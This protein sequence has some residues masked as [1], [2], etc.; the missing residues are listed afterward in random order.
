[1]KKVLFYLMFALFVCS[2]CDIHTTEIVKPGVDIYTKFIT[3]T[4]DEWEQSQTPVGY[5][6]CYLF[7]TF[8][9]KEID[10]NVMDDGAV[11]VYMVDG[12]EGVNPLPYVFPVET[13]SEFVLQNIRFSVKKG[14]I[15]F[16]VE[17]DDA[18]I[19]EIDYDIK[20]KV[21]VL[22]PEK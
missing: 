15:T 9:L 2:G 19:Y 8:P 17:W 22:A 14:Y 6:G 7:K 16:V 1:M 21:C 12:K 5:A 10:R 18:E 20:F 4:P 13:K 3:V 11:M